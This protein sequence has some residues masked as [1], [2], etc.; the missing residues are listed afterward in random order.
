MELSTVWF[1]LLGVLL[2]GYAVLDGFDLGVGIVHLFARGDDERRI[3]LNAIGPLWDGNEV[4]LVT[5]GGALFAAFP[6]DVR[7]QLRDQM[8]IRNYGRGE[9]LFHQGEAATEMFVVLDGMGGAGAGEMASRVGAEVVRDA[10]RRGL[11]RGDEPRALIE[12]A[13]RQL[14][15]L[16]QE[17]AKSR[18]GNERDERKRT[19]AKK[20]RWRMRLAV[21]EDGEKRDAALGERDR[22]LTLDVLLVERLGQAARRTVPSSSLDGAHI[23][24]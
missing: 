8:E 17:P 20:A 19:P 11:K 1:F 9:M 4:W 10:L 5:F 6:E 24:R 2:T 14:L 15:P 13:L 21:G 18:A 12:Q 7:N 16:R 3:L 23:R 22:P